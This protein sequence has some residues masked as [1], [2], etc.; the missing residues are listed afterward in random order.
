MIPHWTL[1][2]VLGGVAILILHV[3]LRLRRARFER[4]AV[5]TSGTVTRV[6]ADSSGEYPVIE[7]SPG[8]ALMAAGRIVTLRDHTAPSGALRVG[9]RVPVS[10]DPGHPERARLETEHAKSARTMMDRLLVGGGALFVALGLGFFS[11]I[12]QLE[13]DE[14][15]REAALEAFLRAVRRGDMAAVRRDAAPGAKLDEAFLRT[16]IRPGTGFKEGS[17]MIGFDDTSCVRGTILPGGQQLVVMLVKRQG[18]F[19]V[20][21][22]ANREKEC[23]DRLD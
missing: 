18:R 15:D 9:D 2:F 21:R 6:D 23:D 3:F 17:S 12:P 22:A 13:A 7:F 1:S 14:A 20:F 10:F 8:G 5:A 19:R 16:Y 4:T 11:F